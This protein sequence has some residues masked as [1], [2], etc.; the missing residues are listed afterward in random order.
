MAHTPLSLTCPQNITIPACQTQ[1]AINTAFNSW[2]TTASAS[3]G[4]NSTLTN[5]NTCAPSFCYCGG[6]KTVTWTA[7][8]SCD[9]TQTCSATFTVSLPSALVFDNLPTGGY[10]GTS[11]SLLPSCIGGVTAHNNCGTVTA[12]CETSGAVSFG[13]CEWIEILTYV[14][15][16]NC[17]NP[18]V[19]DV[20]YTWEG[21]ISATA[22]PGTIL[23]NGGTTTV[24][25]TSSD[26]IAPITYTFNGTSNSTGIFTVGAGGPS[27]FTATDANGCTGTTTGIN[28]S[29]PSPLTV[30]VSANNNPICAGTSTTLTVTASG[31]TGSGTYS[32]S[33]NIIPNPNSATVTVSPTTA[34]NY[35]VTVT[36]RNQCTGTAYIPITMGGSTHVTLCA[37][38]NS[39]CSGSSVVLTA[40]GATSYVW[41]CGLGTGTTKT[42]YPTATP[43]T[44]Y[45][46]T[47]TSNGCTGSAS[48]TVTVHPSPSLIISPNITICPGSFKLYL[49][50]AAQIHTTGVMVWAHA[51]T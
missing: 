31:G 43:T 24:T 46:V 47:G 49:Q 39:V 42:V 6:S 30:S 13:N 33:W 41:C 8:S 4:C 18:L 50:S 11:P 19:E 51:H 12:T 9:P 29:Q 17:V 1:C 27:Y 45:S 40:G 38:P 3:G 48:V 20:I 34:T 35:T 37:N 21:S 28:I 44:T 25:V 23:C 7:T 5:D 22:T 36:D 16:S 10:L 26:G 32:Y 14:A 2:L 15:S